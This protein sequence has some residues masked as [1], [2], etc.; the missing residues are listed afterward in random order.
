MKTFLRWAI[1][2]IVILVILSGGLG[3]W[4]YQKLKLSLP[5]IDGSSSIEGLANQVIVERDHL[6][7]PT[8]RGKTRR[9]VARALGFVHAQDRFFQMDLT[10]RRAAG[11]LAELFGKRAIAVDKAARKNEFRLRK[12]CCSSIYC[13]C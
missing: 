10:R 12:R 3:F 9:D 2:R 13:R 8:I 6:G 5:Q 11:E 1:R 7:V 4:A